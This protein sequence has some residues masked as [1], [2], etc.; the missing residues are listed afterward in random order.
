MIKR[1]GKRTDTLSRAFR[2]RIAEHYGK[3]GVAA[4]QNPIVFHHLCSFSSK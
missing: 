3:R 4:G 1:I 2:Y